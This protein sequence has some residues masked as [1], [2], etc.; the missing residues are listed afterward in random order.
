MGDCVVEDCV[1]FDAFKSVVRVCVV[2]DVC[3]VSV[4]CV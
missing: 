4:C 2:F 3:V 1:V